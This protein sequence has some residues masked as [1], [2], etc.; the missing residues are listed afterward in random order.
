LLT[1]ARFHL[2]GFF[3]E[4]A[5]LFFSSKL[6]KMPSKGNKRDTD[7]LSA[8]N[9]RDSK[10]EIA[11]AFRTQKVTAWWHL[12]IDCPTLCHGALSLIAPDNELTTTTIEHADFPLLLTDRT[13]V[14]CSCDPYLDLSCRHVYLLSSESFSSQMTNIFLKTFSSNCISSDVRSWA[15]FFY[16]LFHREFPCKK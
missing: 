9:C 11:S 1:G 10:G 2:F 14:L 7:D 4:P 15:S 6:E 16:A 13:W 8:P 12:E 3:D 5:L